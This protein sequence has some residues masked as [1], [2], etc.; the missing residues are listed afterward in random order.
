MQKSLLITVLFACFAQAIIA[1]ETIKGLSNM[2]AKEFSKY[3]EKINIVKSSGEPYKMGQGQVAYYPALAIPKKV[4]VINKFF[5]TEA[6]VNSLLD[7]LSIIEISDEEAAH[8]A[9]L[10]EKQ[11]KLLTQVRNRLDNN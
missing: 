9:E 5:A 8:I 10:D 3:E 11:G 4:A 7:I 1:Q 6:R 2:P